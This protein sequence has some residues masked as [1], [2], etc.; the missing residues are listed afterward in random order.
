MIASLC[1]I[2]ALLA[3][4][5]IVPQAWPGGGPVAGAA[6]LLPVVLIGLAARATL[7]LL[8]PLLAF[9]SGLAV[10]SLTGGPLGQW[11]FIYAL[12]AAVAPGMS[13]AGSI[14]QRA[15]GLTGL[16]AL[17]AALNALISASIA[18]GQ[19]GSVSDAVQAA[20]SQAQMAALGAVGILATLGALAILASLAAMIARLTRAVVKKSPPSGSS[21]WR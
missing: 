9:A 11:A 3:A 19:S 1:R 2:V 15:V 4:S 6:V 10:D 8:D 13:G 21:A 5:L 12:A 17:A 20:S 16:V 7:P 14:G 18:V